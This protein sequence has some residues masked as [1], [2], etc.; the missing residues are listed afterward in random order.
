MI[1]APLTDVADINPRLTTRPNA[2]EPVA[3]LGMA[4]VDADTGTTTL[5]ESRPFATVAKGYTPFLDGDLLVAKITPCFENGK[6]VQAKLSLPLGMGSTEFHVIRPR[7]DALD[8][9]YA[10]HMLRTP[11]VR[12]AGERRMTGSA[13]QRRVPAE[14]LHSLS[15]PLPGVDEQQRIADVLDRADAV[16]TQRRRAI[17]MLDD[18]GRAIYEEMFGRAEVAGHASSLKSSLE[19]LAVV[20][21]GITMG[22]KTSNATRPVPYVTVANV[23]ERRLDLSAVKTIEAT[24]AEIE[25]YRLLAGDLL[26]T[27]GGDPD[28]LGRGTLWRGELDLCIH[29]NHV[30]RVRV[31]RPDLLDATYLNWHVGSRRGKAYFLRSAKQTTGIASINST[32]LKGFPVLLPPLSE[33]AKFADRITAISQQAAA[34]RQALSAVDGLLCTLQHRAFLGEL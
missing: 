30:F 12:A 27:E 33:Q 10:L 9:R 24:E 8:P 14:F 11:A 15:I 4:D 16:R 7:P 6:I 23:Q 2:D 25:R 19:E 28:K 31:K 29:Q 26:L 13:G 18:L 3:F 17:S 5:G 32:Q 21:S 1:H 22:R 34:A 20:S